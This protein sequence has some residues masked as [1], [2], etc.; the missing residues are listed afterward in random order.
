MI[1]GGIGPDEIRKSPKHIE[2]FKYFFAARR[3][4]SSKGIDILIRAYRKIKRKLPN[5]K[6]LIAD[7]GPDDQLL[8]EPIY[9]LKLENNVVLLDPIGHSKVISYMKG[10]IAHICPSR[11]EGGGIVNYEAQAAKC[12]AIGS[13]AGGIPEYIEN[14]RTGLVFPV[15]EKKALAKLLLFVVKYKK[16]VERLKKQPKLKFPKKLGT[17]FQIYI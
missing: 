5:T 6:L 10:A 16:E 12:L 3:L 15:G 1:Y 8:T 11:T 9:E 4:D 2:K 13:D 17:H 7:E 14:N